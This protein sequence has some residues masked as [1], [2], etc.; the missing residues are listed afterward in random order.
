MKKIV[1]RM[2]RAL[3]RQRGYLGVANRRILGGSNEPVG[4][5]LIPS[6]GDYLIVDIATG[7]KIIWS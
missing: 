2:L 1:R 6:A 4:N 5:F 3:S 7:D